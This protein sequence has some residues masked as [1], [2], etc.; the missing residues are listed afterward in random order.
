MDSIYFSSMQEQ[1]MQAFGRHLQL[2]KVKDLEEFH[3]TYLV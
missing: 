3:M 1:E 2:V